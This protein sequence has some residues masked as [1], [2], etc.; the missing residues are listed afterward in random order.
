MERDASPLLLC[1]DMVE[2]MQVRTCS[3]EQ[4]PIVCIPC[5]LREQ[6]L[7]AKRVVVG[8]I[9]LGLS[10]PACPLPMTCSVGV[11]SL[12]LSLS[13]SL[14]CGC[15]RPSFRPFP[16]DAQRPTV[17]LGRLKIAKLCQGGLRSGQRGQRRAW[18]G[19][20]AWVRPTRTGPVDG[21]SGSK[22]SRMTGQ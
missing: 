18:G 14:N 5:C 21:S 17:Q 1:V 11:V 19:P 7:A 22:W 12:S 16:F 10:E 6:V 9:S 3:L 2:C 13:Q 4:T 20:G 8:A 15:R